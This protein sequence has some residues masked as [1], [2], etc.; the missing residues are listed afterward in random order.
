MIAGGI[1]RLAT[2][3]PAKLLKLVFEA[4]GLI[5]DET[6]GR[7]DVPFA[8][9]AVPDFLELAGELVQGGGPTAILRPDAAILSIGLC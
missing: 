3:H 6:G 2:V 4:P 9:F 1:C 7:H 5:G 8:G